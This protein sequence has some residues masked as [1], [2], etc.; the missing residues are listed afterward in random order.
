VNIVPAAEGTGE[1]TVGQTSTK[2]RCPSFAFGGIAA[3]EDST[4]EAVNI[5]RSAAGGSV[6]AEGDRLSREVSF[7]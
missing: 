1:V 6:L 7:V 3:I 2:N 4:V 5:C